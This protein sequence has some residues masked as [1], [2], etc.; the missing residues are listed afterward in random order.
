MDSLTRDELSSFF[1]PPHSPQDNEHEEEETKISSVSATSAP[2]VLSTRSTSV[3]PAI[4][5]P[6]PRARRKRKAPRCGSCGTLGHIRTNS[7][8]P[9]KRSALE[10]KMLKTTARSRTSTRPSFPETTSSETRRSTTTTT[11]TSSSSRSTRTASVPEDD[12]PSESLHTTPDA[13][14]LYV[15]DDSEEEQ[16]PFHLFPL[17]QA[18]EPEPEEEE[19]E[20][21]DTDPC[22]NILNALELHLRSGTNPSILVDTLTTFGVACGLD[23]LSIPRTLLRRIQNCESEAEGQDR[24]ACRNVL[25][26]VDQRQL[27]EDAPVSREVLCNLEQHLLNPDEEDESPLVEDSPP[28]ALPITEHEWEPLPPDSAFY[29]DMVLAQRRAQQ[30]IGTDLSIAPPTLAEYFVSRWR[31]RAILEPEEEAPVVVL[32]ELPSIDTKHEE[33]KETAEE[34]LCVVC[35]CAKKTE[36]FVPCTHVCVCALCRDS[37]VARARPGTLPKCPICRSEFHRS[38]RVFI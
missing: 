18:R 10:K 29:R 7:Q 36:C 27:E 25:S 38:F 24:T 3:R 16:E 37:L 4:R 9:N 8:C 20:L 34:N 33:E 13:F 17:D 30:V 35:L 11:T 26:K 1:E 22:I 12:K 5:S 23:P 28:R 2:H 6:P 14:Y 32:K 21:D 15:S 19:Q 31:S